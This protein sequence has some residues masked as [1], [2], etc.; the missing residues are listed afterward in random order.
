MSDVNLN[1]WKEME[2]TIVKLGST[3]V[4]KEIRHKYFNSSITDDVYETVWPIF[5][6]ELRQRMEKVYEKYDVDP[7]D[8]EPTV[9]RTRSRIAVKAPKNFEELAEVQAAAKKRKAAKKAP[10]IREISEDEW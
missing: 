9:K 10:A 2:S 4:A 8:I 3:N 1:M 6:A 7:N 5:A